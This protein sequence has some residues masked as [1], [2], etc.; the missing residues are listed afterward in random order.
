M[1]NCENIFKEEAAKFEQIHHK[2]MKEKA[3][4]STGSERSSFSLTLRLMYTT[5]AKW[6]IHITETDMCFSLADTVSKFEEDKFPSLRRTR[7]GSI[8]DM[9]N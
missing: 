3:E 4:L 5:I 9:S 2:F 8:C 6:D 7:R 1:W